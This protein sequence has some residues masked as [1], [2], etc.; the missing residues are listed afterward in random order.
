MPL[1][2]EGWVYDER[3]LTSIVSKYENILPN[4]YA[5]P[6]EWL[7]DREGYPWAIPSVKL[8]ERLRE[9]DEPAARLSAAMVPP[10]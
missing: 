4:P 5:Q 6:T 3:D 2:A 10:A 7:H 8:C 1:L 9:R